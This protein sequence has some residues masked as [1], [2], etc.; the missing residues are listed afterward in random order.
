MTEVA[1]VGGGLAGITAALECADAGASVT[2]FESRSRLGGATFSIERN[3]LWLDNGQHIALR[4]CTE[5]RRLLERLGTERFLDVQSRL[6]IPVLDVDGRAARFNRTA[7]PAPFHLSGTILRYAHLTVRER[8]AVGRAVLALRRVDPDEPRADETPFAGWLRAHG[9]SEN[10]IDRLWDLVTLPTLNLNAEHASLALAA[11]VFQTGLLTESDAGDV[12]VPTVP[13]ARLHGDAAAAA[14]RA[15]DVRIRQRAKVRSVCPEDGGFRIDLA[16]GQAT[17]DRV[18]LAVP[19]D[20]APELLP[21][22]VYDAES[23][24]GLGTSPIVNVHLHYDR[25]VIATPVAAV[26]ASPPFW[27]F[28]RTGS[29]GVERGQLLALSIS[30]ADA[31]VGLP[32][33]EIVERSAAAVARF[34]PKAAAATLLDSVVTRE[35]RA[36]FR[37]RPGTARL[38][39]AAETSIPG[40]A[41][42]GAWTDTGWPATMEGAVRSGLAAARVA[43]ARPSGRRL[44][45]AA[46]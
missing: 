9:Q 33:A 12:V 42:A 25:Q 36:T 44:Q 14:L 37:A 16:D 27:V 21:A 23:A 32:Q 5:Y 6:S 4:C 29:A 28:D 1:V 11:F 15:R 38:R 18:V 45:E 19:H 39:P 40:L 13:L 20:V 41:L 43:L 26:L 24:Q 8:I 3:G 10:A 30:G 17:A 7:L 2:V 31:D 35:P 34:A 46:A 22:G